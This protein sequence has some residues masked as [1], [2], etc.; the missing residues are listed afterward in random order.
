MRPDQESESL[1]ITEIDEP[2]ITQSNPTLINIV[3]EDPELA[4]IFQFINFEP[5]EIELEVNLKCFLPEYIPV[6]G[7]VCLHL[8]VFKSDFYVD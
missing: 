3:L 7:D 1:G 5:K 8:Q 6:L 4:E 2:F